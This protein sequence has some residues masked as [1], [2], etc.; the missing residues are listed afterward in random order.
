MKVVEYEPYVL[1]L[2]DEI[3]SGEIL[4]AH[5]RRMNKEKH[6]G[7]DQGDVN[8]LLA[9]IDYLKRELSALTVAMTA[10]ANA[11]VLP[12]VE[13]PGETKTVRR[14]MAETAL[15]VEARI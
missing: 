11:I 8:S 12:L 5:L 13:E 3:H 1:Q 7:I 10:K 15:R 4:L 14:R 6:E 2:R 9:D